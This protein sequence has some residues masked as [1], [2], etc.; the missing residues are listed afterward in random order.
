VVFTLQ[1]LTT[2][3]LLSILGLP[4]SLWAFRERPLYTRV[5]AAPASGLALGSVILFTAAYF[6]PMRVAAWAILLPL[7]V[8]AGIIGILLNR[9]WD[10]LTQRVRNRRSVGLL[11]WTLAA[12][13]MAIAIPAV[14]LGLLDSRGPIGYLVNDATGGYPAIL[15]SLQ[16][17][18]LSDP[19]PWGGSW[20]L[21]LGYGQVWAAGFQQGGF[22]AEAAAMASLLGWNVLAYQSAL[23]GALIVT[24]GL[25]MAALVRSEFPDAPSYVPAA[26][27]LLYGGPLTLD[28]FIE[29]S[30]AALSGLALLPLTLLALTGLRRTIRARPAFVLAVVLAAVQTVYPVVYPL[31]VAGAVLVVLLVVLRS[32]LLSRL[33]S[34]RVVRTAASALAPVALVVVAS[35]VLSPVALSRN[36]EYW[37]NLGGGGFI[38]AL[39]PIFPQYD[40]GFSVA[41]PWLAQLRSFPYLQTSLVTSPWLIMLSVATVATLAVSLLHMVR[42][43]RLGV[44][45]AFVAITLGAGAIVAG[46]SPTCTYCTQRLAVFVGPLVLLLLLFGVAALAADTRRL[47]RIAAPLALL[48]LLGAAGA[49]SASL[50]SRAVDDAYALPT[51][52]LDASA[53]LRSL[54]GDVLLEG[55]NAS[56]YAVSEFPALY[57]AAAMS[58]HRISVIRGDDYHFGWAFWPGKDAPVFEPTYRLVLTRFGAVSTGRRTIARDGPFAIQERVRVLD[59][60]VVAGVVTDR[61]DRDRTGKAWID[62]RLVVRVVSPR[63]TRVHLEIVMRQDGVQLDRPGR[64]VRLRKG[65]AAVCLDAGVVDGV[66]DVSLRLL[67]REGPAPGS[68]RFD[69]RARPSRE[70][71]LTRLVPSAG[72]C[73]S[74]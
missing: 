47:G 20:N 46:A 13:I 12:V 38:D 54:D 41:V 25:A 24:G 68:S 43:R 57:Y 66:K 37:S 70:V 11:A 50:I 60:V 10:G 53:R 44:P 61:S 17:H 74:A 34:G 19:A 4:A 26:A 71:E 9:P 56:Y 3:A 28:L 69:L 65:L 5:C 51:S 31:I 32:G 16:Q 39:S 42:T 18:A 67:Q 63:A 49:A 48:C 7:L 35:L 21:M 72:R 8:A 59:A 27:C 6:M 22:E 36:I 23:L 73:G 15:A 62:G 40:L 14:P 30:E 52:A 64:L 1:A 58:G 33:A 55:A 29:G 45:I 2:V